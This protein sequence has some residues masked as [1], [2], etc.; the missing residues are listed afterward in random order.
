MG[1]GFGRILDAVAGRAADGPAWC[2]N[3]HLVGALLVAGTSSDA[4]KSIVTAGLCRWLAR[5]GFSVAPFKAQNMS[6]NSFVTRAGEEIGRAQAAQ[7]AACG[8]EPEAAMN[9]VLLKPGS[10]THSQLIVCGKA[11]TETDAAGYWATGRQGRLLDVVVGAYHDLAA[12]FDMVIC[13]GAGSPAEINLRDTDIVNLGF[14]R[15][16]GVPVVLVGDIDRGG[17]FASFV[18]TVAVL[19]PAD[20]AHVAGFIVNKFR[21]DVSLLKPGLHMLEQL[22]GRPTLGVLPFADGIGVDAEDAIDWALLRS[23]G[24]PLGTDVLR[25]TV[26]ALPRMSNH[27]DVDALACEPGVLVRFARQAAELAD[28]DLVVL[29]GSRATVSDLAW[30]RARQIDAAIAGHVA[31]G[32][33]VLGICGGYQMLGTLIEDDVESRAGQVPGLGLLPVRTAF[34][35]EK[36]LARPTRTLADGVVVHGYEIH[37][38]VLSRDGG[39]PFFADEGCRIEGVAGTVWHGLLE[40]DSFRREYLAYVAR[41]AGRGFTG[42]PDTSF[43]AIREARL[44]RLADL[45][46][47]HLDQEQLLS[48]LASGG[49]AFP[50]LRLTLG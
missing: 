35:R 17:V 24:P 19:D 37:H 30:L 18:G 13:E 10:D 48:L 22:T 44:D 41:V 16:A 45:V 7:A 47:D 46:A 39:E 4:G 3:V 26:V 34:G 33:P 28:A 12:R 36:V 29:P 5:Q 9:P 6:L 11:V 49:R 8:I 14:A 27:T 20:Q 23:G 43:A 15:A 38:G 31:R 1:R 40:N 50:P 21:G 25:V 42:A 2:P 32:L